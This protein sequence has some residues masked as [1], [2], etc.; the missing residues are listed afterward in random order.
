MTQNETIMKI[1]AILTALED[2][3]GS[4]ESMLYI[5]CDMDIHYWTS[6]KA[7]MLS[8]KLINISAN[9]VTLTDKG[10]RTAQDINALIAK[11]GMN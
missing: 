1:A 6:L 7:L 3:G 11:R 2:T 5:F 9:F 4:P 8:G 10:K